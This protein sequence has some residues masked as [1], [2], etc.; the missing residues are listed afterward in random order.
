MPC[1]LLLLCYVSEFRLNFTQK[2]LG[3]YSHIIKKNTSYD[4]K[5]RLNGGSSE[6]CKHM[7][8]H[9]IILWYVLIIVPVCSLCVRS[10]AN[11]EKYF[12]KAISC[13]TTKKTPLNQNVSRYYCI[14]NP[15]KDDLPFLITV[16]ILIESVRNSCPHKSC[17][18]LGKH[19]CFS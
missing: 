18:A 12:Q 7:S 10:N 11:F 13:N 1:S 4:F 9:G 15:E 6:Y 5:T 14:Y 19:L 16:N 3:G 17:I 2:N 8:G